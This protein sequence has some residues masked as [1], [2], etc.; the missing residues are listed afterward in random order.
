VLAGHVE[1][2]QARFLQDLVG[3]VE[4]LRLGE[5]AHVA[6]VQDEGGLLGHR[7][8]LGHGLAEGRPRV[9]VRILGEADV[10][11]GHLDEGEGRHGGLGRPRGGF[12]RAQQ[13]GAGHAAAHRPDQARS[14][15]AH[16]L[17]ETSAVGFVHGPAPS[18][19][20]DG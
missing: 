2:G 3:V 7:P 6:G 12:R 8:D 15:P 13:A 10:A 19:N 9:R 4:L 11:V 17:Q 5:L 16:A 18:M 14:G 1:H 20:F